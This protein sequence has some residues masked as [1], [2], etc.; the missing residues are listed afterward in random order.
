[1]AAV[2]AA[3][4]PDIDGNLFA[5]LGRYCREGDLDELRNALYHEKD[6]LNYFLIRTQ[7]GYTLL[8]EAVEAEQADVVQLLLLHGVSP[9]IRARN[10]LT[11]LHIAASKGYVSCVRTLLEN[12]ADLTLQDELGMD[13]MQ[14]AEKSKRKDGVQ[15]LLLSKGAFVR[16]ER[17]VN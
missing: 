9:N 6:V 17:G 10:G 3:E 7:R 5:D 1:M 11:P 13:V 4:Y 8:H 14:K 16:A 2:P 15:R 12:G